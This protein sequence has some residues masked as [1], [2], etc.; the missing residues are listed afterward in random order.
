M[1][2]LKTSFGYGIEISENVSIRNLISCRDKTV[3]LIFKIIYS[4]IFDFGIHIEFGMPDGNLTRVIFISQEE[5]DTKSSG[6]LF[7]ESIGKE[8]LD[9]SI[10]ANDLDDEIEDFSD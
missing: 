9:I 3:N 4:F 6:Y 2:K 8:D 7:S 5:L 1:S 10:L